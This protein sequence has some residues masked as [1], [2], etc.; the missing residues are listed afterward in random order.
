MRRRFEE[1]YA[2]SLARETSVRQL[3][4]TSPSVSQVRGPSVEAC[5]PRWQWRGGIRASVAVSL[6]GVGR[7]RSE[8]T[9]PPLVSAYRFELSGSSCQVRAVRG[10]SCGRLMPAIEALPVCR[11][12]LRYSLQVYTCRYVQV[13]PRGRPHLY[14]GNAIEAYAIEPD[15]TRGM[16]G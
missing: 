15:S 5:L 7:R 12:S 3:S 2:T 13:E 8:V 10:S 4:H 9:R 11:Y 14:T 1:A 16:M 6:G